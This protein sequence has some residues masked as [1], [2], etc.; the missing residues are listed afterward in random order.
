MSVRGERDGKARQGVAASTPINMAGHLQAA[1]I[2]STFLLQTIMIKNRSRTQKRIDAI[3]YGIW[4]SMLGTS[5]PCWSL[6]AC[7]LRAMS[8]RVVLNR[9][10]RLMIAG[11]GTRG[12]PSR[13]RSVILVLES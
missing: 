1:H 6:G 8:L 2:V 5:Q 11:S 13:T 9:K 4:C 12:M 7:S 3:R 10:I